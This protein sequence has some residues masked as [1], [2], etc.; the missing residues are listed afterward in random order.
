MHVPELSETQ[1][2][3]VKACYSGFRLASAWPT[4][5][6]VDAVLDHDHDLDYQAI[7]PTLPRSLVL[8]EPGYAQQSLVKITVAGL[9]SVDAAAG[10]LASFIA[11][12]RAGADRE[13]ALR[14]SP[15]GTAQ[16]EVTAADADEIWG[17]RPA[18]DE[19]A[20]VVE[21]ANVEGIHAGFRGVGQ[22][23][24][25]SME[26]NRWV[27]PYRGVRDVDDYLAR[28]PEP[29]PVS[30]APPPPA[31][32]YTF[33]LMPFGTAWS[34]NVKNTM[35]LACGQVSQLF[36]GLSWERADEITE[37]GRIT[38]QIVTAIERSDVLIADIT[39]TNPNV[40]FELGYADAL[41]KAVIVL[42]QEVGNTPFDI[43]DWRQIEYSLDDLPALR[44]SLV[45]F[46]S[47]ALRRQRF[48]A[49][50]SHPEETEP[51]R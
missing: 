3:L 14:P 27:R 50:A 36:A 30:W 1:L 12:L 47:G 41:G 38:D 49:A 35:D 18:P 9:R 40:L 37:T 4:N 42:N 22:E 8:A 2:A 17:R 32:P 13:R 11:L 19:L 21:I 34:R 25:W 39:G 28:R 6:Y 29:V 31:A 24:D 44:D 43:K 16:A 46:L 45:D 5:A 33:I 23:G 7:V 15:T 10:D 51:L 26:F 20:R 48:P